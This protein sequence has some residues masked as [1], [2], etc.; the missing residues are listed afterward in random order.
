VFQVEIRGLTESTSHWIG[1]RLWV[2][3]KHT[4]EMNEKRLQHIL[5]HLEPNDF[6]T[7]ST[8]GTLT[9]DDVQELIALRETETAKTVLELMA[10]PTLQAKWKVFEILREPPF[11]IDAQWEFIRYR[12]E[13]HKQVVHF[14][15]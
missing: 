13:I 12:E 8:N 7:F 3:I 1:G 11:T 15:V 5:R 10:Y 14:E 2:A 4:L 9:E 6:E